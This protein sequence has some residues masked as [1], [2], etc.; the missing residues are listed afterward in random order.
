MSDSLRKTGIGII[1]DVPWGTHFCQFYRT[2]QDLLDILVP[3][4]SEGLRNNEF[5]M[6][7]TSEPLEAEDARAA[8]AAAL[9][10][11]DDRARQ[12]Q[13]EIIPHTEWYLKGGSFDSGRVLDG[14]VKK[15][16]SALAAGY[17]GLR[18]TG[19]T[20]W[21]EQ[22]DWKAFTDYEAEVDRVI[23][24][25]RMLAV[26][27]YSLDRCGANEILDV[28]TNHRIALVRREARWELVESAEGKLAND[29]LKRSA[30]FPEQ[31]PNPVLR[32]TVGGDL[33][34]ANSPASAVMEAM[35]RTEGGPV[36]PSVRALALEAA[37][38]S[39]VFE[40]ELTDGRDRTFWF[41]AIRP[42]KEPYVNLYARDITSRKQAENSLH[43]SRE[44][45]RVTLTSIGD[46]VIATDAEGRITFLN[47]VASSLTGW[48]G[49]EAV[50]RPIREVFQIINE[51]THQPAEDIFA[52]VISEGRSIALS[53]NTAL[54]TRDGREVPIE[55]SAAPILDA[56]G[57][58]AGVVL[59]FHDVTARREAQRALRDNEE[60]CR[61]LFE[62][63]AEGFALYELVDD[64]AGRPIDWRV[65]EVN[66][67]YTRYTGISREQIVGRRISEV[68]PIAVPDYLPI[69]SRV[70]A[71]QTPES[72]ETFAK[73][74][75]RYQ[76]IFTF[77]VG[78]RRFASTIEDIS[79]R[80]SAEEALRQSKD[81]LE[82]KVR[83]RTADLQQTNEQL[84]KE[85]QERM[86]TEQSLRLEE[87][88]LDALLHL[89]Q[90]SEAP[91]NEITGFTLEQAIALTRSKIG[92]V[93]F[94]SKDESVYTLHAVSKDVVKECNV[95]GDPVQWHV[96]DAG[97]WADAI[98]ERRT[99][100]VNDYSRP[101][102]RKKGLPPGH[103]YVERFMVVPI[104]EGKRI[105][106]LAGVGNKASDYDK[107][108]ER[109]IFLLLNGMWGGVQKNRSRE[110][111]E[112]AYYE[113]EE[114]VEQR[115]ASLRES[116]ERLK[117]AQ[118]IAHI[119]SWELDLVDN[120][121]TWSDEVYRIFG[122]QP[123][124]FGAT[125]EAFLNAIHP[126]D[127]A[128]VDA[129]YSGSVR[130]GRDSYEIEHRIVRRHTGEIR[131]VY[132]KCEHRR[133]AAGRIVS[134]IG[135]VHDV[136]ETRKAEALRQAL[137]EQERLRLGAAVEQASDS[138]V[139]I[140][141]DGT[142]L[143]V[144]AA[145]ESIN[146][147]SR[148]KAVGRL[149]FGLSGTDA[150]TDAIRESVARGQAW[151]GQLTRPVPTGRPVELEV[152]ISPATDPAGK[153]IGGLVTEKDVTQEG[154][155]QRQV[156]QAQKMEALG[157]LAGGITHDFNNILSTIFINTELAMLDLDPANPAR[158]SLPIV[159]QAANRGKELAKQIITFSRQ[160]EWER[161]PLEVA[162]IV[163]EGMKF[164]RSTLPK[165][166]AI[167]ESIAADC[168]PVLAD[169]SQIHQI[170]IN[171]C[172]NASL[173]MADGTGHLEVKLEPVEVD[174]ALAA[175]HPDLK[176]GPH[177]RMTVAD[178]G[179]GMSPE[180][181]ERIFEPFFT[182]RKHG[183][184]SGLG[185]AVVHGVVKSYDGAITVYSEPGKGSVFNIYIP[186]LAGEA[187]AGEK[188]NRVQPEK[189]KEHILLV[190]DEEAQLKGTA[191]LLERLGYRVTAKPT[192]RTALAAFK[193]NPAAFDLVVTDQAMPRMTGIELAKALVKVR[194]DIP[195][196]LCTG[197]SEKVNGETVGHDGIQA[198]VMKPF[199]IQEI[200]K[201]IRATLKR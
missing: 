86:E 56:A 75:G 174:A 49:D 116:E 100:F 134:S 165:D 85:N 87:A 6:W 149:Y 101:H 194:P 145:F 69:F 27:T 65:L 114:R 164:L 102:P 147:I 148:D 115:T 54:R 94:L 47:P 89:G 137:A 159:L 119:G 83:D 55:D 97:I 120:R 160:R 1:G 42:N 12:G 173:A 118:E 31:N 154:A 111:L 103:P 121:L 185:L 141:L 200:S 183:E 22:K 62:N 123:Q 184:G 14:W 80:K 122:L 43:R 91:L 74:V 35:G 95:T 90:I 28:I 188:G 88:R 169:P 181:M 4:F 124:E 146:R 34:Y 170:L 107:A 30:Q 37:E 196:I 38:R 5:C 187:L 105:V 10:D 17:E 67:A 117:R 168:G 29:E 45:L 64:E 140:N 136:T 190:E 13:I 82:I 33:I 19:N 171:L 73:A 138:V 96:V 21:F 2:P 195:I 198:F 178:T 189:G 39:S 143:Y 25:F 193:K 46:A 7:I 93:G 15:L 142:I 71:T 108:D 16:D 167:H 162:P 11:L 175:R 104:L 70:V 151:H 8:L 139:M 128:A 163:K 44:S 180:L 98:K 51:L 129:T 166:I 24:Q 172:Q 109:Q 110:E 77:P 132:E 84:K 161:K 112:K 127:R 144:N 52:R 106:A 63:M 81:E 18:L 76:R 157:T 158:R 59:V 50:G 113:L 40:T 126:E 26:C 53:S 68:F 176:P 135:M 32:V 133:D 130:E 179:C 48:A 186:R 9:P 66:D 152:T 201:Q 182:T 131:V 197:F 150:P 199:T 177:V 60:K 57:G 3:Y 36:P 125:Y 20:F 72:F 23:G 41:A 92:F 155:L 191:R 61:L 192:G 78:G 156:R 99:L 58:L 153:I 79:A